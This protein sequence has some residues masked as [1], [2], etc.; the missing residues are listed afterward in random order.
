MFFLSLG[1]SETGAF[2][3]DTA[4]SSNNTFT[5][6]EEFGEG[7][8]PA[9][10]QF[11]DVVINEIM[12]MGSASSSAD[13]WIELKN[14]TSN[15]IDLTGWI[16]EGLG[17][18]SNQTATVSAGVIS[19][20]NFFLISH[21]DENSTSSILDVV[22]DLLFPSIAFTNTGEEIVLKTPSGTIID[23]ADN[24]GEGWLAGD[25]DFPRRS[26]ERKSPPDNGTEGSNW[27]NSTG[28]TNLDS[29]IQEFATPKAANSS[30][31]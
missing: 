28:Q 18:G 25:D 7:E 19:A 31:S 24:S 21:F 4:V 1:F 15:D 3:T 9:S 11:G 17:S 6:A 8:P 27:H 30:G 10:P 2:F 20:N 23:V 13:E 14:M 5:T 29:E 12:W 22:P 26:M 16:I